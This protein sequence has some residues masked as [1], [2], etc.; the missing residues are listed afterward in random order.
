MTAT[1]FSKK[2]GSYGNGEKWSQHSIIWHKE[3]EVNCLATQSAQELHDNNQEGNE[4]SG[5]TV[6]LCVNKITKDI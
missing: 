3:K 6:T 1:I 5:Y 2:R 4:L